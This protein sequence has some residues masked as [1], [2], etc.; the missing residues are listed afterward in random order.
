[1]IPYGP[2]PLSKRIFLNRESNPWV[3]SILNFPAEHSAKKNLASPWN[4]KMFDRSKFSKLLYNTY[5]VAY[6]LILFRLT[7]AAW[8]GFIWTEP[9]SYRTN[10]CSREFS[11]QEELINKPGEL[12]HV[13]LCN[14]YEHVLYNRCQYSGISTNILDMY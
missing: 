9:C 14:C 11:F 1:M 7:T 12:I 4:L 13:T 2:F 3:I 6:L 8:Y 10:N 5:I